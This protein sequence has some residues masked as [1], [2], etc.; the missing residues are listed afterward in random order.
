MAGITGPFRD[1]VPVMS[2]VDVQPSAVLFGNAVAGV[3]RL[4][5]GPPAPPLRSLV[6]Y[7]RR[8]EFVVGL[9]KRIPGDSHT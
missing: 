6:R 2:T 8:P 7:V 9:T 3:I 1:S 5:A 4:L